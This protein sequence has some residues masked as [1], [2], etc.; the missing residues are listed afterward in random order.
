MLDPGGFDGE[1]ATTA[2]YLSTGGGNSEDDDV[3]DRT[4]SVRSTSSS[5]V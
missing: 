1:M 4:K 3:V 2:L 5:W